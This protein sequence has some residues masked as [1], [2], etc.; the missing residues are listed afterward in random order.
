MSVTPKPRL[1]FAPLASALGDCY[2]YK[3]NCSGQA[4]K[5]NPTTI[6]AELVGASRRTLTRWVSAG[7]PLEHADRIA[8]SLGYHVCEI[9]PE[10]FDESE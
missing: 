5:G 8:C 9:W 2:V 6:L 10:W 4:V 3:N 1:P 7:V